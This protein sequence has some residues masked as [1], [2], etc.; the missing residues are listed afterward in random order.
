MNDRHSVDHPFKRYTTPE[1]PPVVLPPRRN[2]RK[3]DSYGIFREAMV[4]RGKDWIWGNQDGTDG[5]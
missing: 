5:G 3:I 1:L 4:K 2:S